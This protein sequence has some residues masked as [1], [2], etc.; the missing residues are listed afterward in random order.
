MENNSDISFEVLGSKF[1][2]NIDIR[3]ERH[4]DFIASDMIQYKDPSSL[5]AT[6]NLKDTEM[7][8]Y[9]VVCSAGEW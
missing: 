7:G 9:D 2:P 1:S 6:F 3:L 4:G 5:V 8:E